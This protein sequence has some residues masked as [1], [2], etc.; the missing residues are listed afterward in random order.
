M[1]MMEENMNRLFFTILLIPA[2]SS[3]HENLEDR[4]AREAKEYTEKYCP[5]P[6]VNGSRTDSVTFQK[7]TKTYTYYCSFVGKLDNAQIV[8][9][10]RGKIH[11]LMVK[12]IKDNT[13]IRKLKDAKYNFAYVVHSD[14]NPQKILYQQTIRVSDYQ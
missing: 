10:N 6:V 3:C 14:K 1:L 2:L 8:A 11:R 5:T 13:S 4:S 9:R 12:E 7:E